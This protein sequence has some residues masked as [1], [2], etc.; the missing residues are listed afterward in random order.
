MV[1][2]SRYA[3]G[4]SLLVLSL[5]IGCDHNQPL[6]P[7][8]AEASLAPNAGNQKGPS[9]LSID[10]APGELGL[11]WRDNSPNETGFEVLRST[12]GANGAFATIATP[13]ANATYYSDT[14]LDPAQEYCYKVQAVAQKRIIG[15]SNTVCATPLRLQPDAASNLDAFLN[16]VATVTVTWTD[17]SYNEDGFKVARVP[18]LAGPWVT[19]A[20]VGAGVT[21]FQDKA[22][23]PGQEP[24]CYEV[25]AFNKFGGAKASN[26]DCTAFPFAPTKLAVVSVDDQTVDLSWEDNSS[27]EDGYEVQR[28]CVPGWVVVA[29]L[30]ADVA[31]YRDA[32]FN[33]NT[34][35]SYQVRAKKDQ[36]YSLD[37]TAFAP[38]RAPQGVET[39]PVSSS[40]VQVYWDGS[41][42]ARGFR[43]DRSTDGGGS[44]S[45]VTLIPY[46]LPVDEGLTAEQTVCYRVIEFNEQGDSPP[47]DTSCT[48]P[49][50]A[51]T[52]PV[53]TPIDAQTVDLAWTDNSNVEDGYVVGYFFFDDYSYQWLF[54]DVV[55]LPANT[56]GYRLTYLESD[57]YAVAA[58][59]DGGQSDYAG[60]G[61]VT[62]SA[63]AP[64]PP[65]ST[66]G[67]RTM[68]RSGKPTPSPR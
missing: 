43:I 31:K 55:H 68:T 36:G 3:V 20:T 65:M 44:W 23:I 25:V 28:C 48:V 49:P 67:L 40:S 18:N 42:A 66:S 60:F 35:Y 5:L 56:T 11:T 27:V 63:A 61:S 26:T 32:T 58:T 9:N 6:A 8:A 33:A 37:L 62:G 59:R 51:P 50:L 15:V 22:G 30:P 14:G 12:T 39:F 2:V 47:S 24:V 57:T 4:S 52:E 19:I 64:A 45:A 46:A 53:A 29:N 54:Q 7:D 10:A 17:N 16:G 13:P 21:S 41:P 1:A 38:L 34:I